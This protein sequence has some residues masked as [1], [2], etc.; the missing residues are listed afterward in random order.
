MKNLKLLSFLL[1]CWTLVLSWCEKANNQ[2]KLSCDG[3]EVCPIE[4]TVENWGII[5]NDTPSVIIDENA[6][7]S[8]DW[9]EEV[10]RVDE[11]DL[12]WDLPSFVWWDD[13][14]VS[15][16]GEQADSEK[17]LMKIMVDE[18]ASPEEIEITASQTC[19][20]LGWSW[21]EWDCTLE[22]GSKVYF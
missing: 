2:E 10:V 21:N 3:N 11:W 1:L 14:L 20:A 9:N 17:P 22:D 4:D 13:G 16:N 12:E 8:L 5:I 15:E 19:E 6:E 18:N 7:W